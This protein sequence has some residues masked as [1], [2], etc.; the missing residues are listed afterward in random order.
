MR[1]I[2]EEERQSLGEMTDRQ[3][4]QAFKE[5]CTQLTGVLDGYLNSPSVAD[6]SHRAR[7]ALN[8]LATVSEDVNKRSQEAVLLN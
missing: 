1:W 4:D 2:T 8:A 3:E 6:T 7:R 5:L